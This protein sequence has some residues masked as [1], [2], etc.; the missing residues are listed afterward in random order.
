[1]NTASVHHRPRLFAAGL[2]AGLALVT[3]LAQAEVVSAAA[4][5]Q[6]LQEGAQPWDVRTASAAPLL[7]GAVRLDAQACLDWLAAGDTQALSAAVSA[8]GIDLSRDVLIYGEAG[9]GR[10]QALY[11]ALQQLATGRVLWLVGGVPEWQMSGRQTA[12]S[13]G[14]R[15]PVPQRLVSLGATVSAR[16]AAASLRDPAASP[17]LL[18]TR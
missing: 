12:A 14:T 8:A 3:G 1:M 10:A 2:F 6:R 4:A 11:Q 15:L 5:E 16:M 9:D 18:A 13:A 17:E 7:P